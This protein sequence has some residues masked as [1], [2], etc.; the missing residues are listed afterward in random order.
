[1]VRVEQLGGE[2]PA[3]RADNNNDQQHESERGNDRE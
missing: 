2:H 1:M 3:D